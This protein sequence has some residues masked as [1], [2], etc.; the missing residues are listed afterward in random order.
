MLEPTPASS[1]LSIL[2][3]HV[4]PL[5]NYAWHGFS[6]HGVSCVELAANPYTRVR[7]QQQGS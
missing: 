4:I 6:L 1:C 3:D 2:A 5:W 7:D